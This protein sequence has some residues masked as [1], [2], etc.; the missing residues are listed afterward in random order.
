ME[1]I[2]TKESRKREGQLPLLPEHSS[3]VFDEGHLLEY[4][5]QKAL[6][7][8]F[9]D[10]ILETLL[11]KLME[12]DVREKT[13]YMIEDVISQNEQFFYELKNASNFHEGS[14]K[15]TIEKTVSVLS[16]GK[17]LFKLISSLEEELVLES[18]LFT[19]NEYELRYC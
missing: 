9:T 1:H 19:I 2:W 8:R 7:Y 10:Y 3:V 13:L 15:M 4:A 6:R 12:N 16:S 14:D 11:T 18:E 17:Q 5:A